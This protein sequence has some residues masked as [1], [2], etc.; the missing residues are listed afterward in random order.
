MLAHRVRP[1]LLALLA[2]AL[3]LPGVASSPPAAAAAGAAASCGCEESGEYDTPSAIEDP[4]VGGDGS[5]APTNPTYRLEA[6]GGAPSVSLTVR[7][8]AGNSQVAVIHTTHTNWGFSP[9]QQRLV[10]WRVSA[11]N[12]ELA[13]YDLGSDR[14]GTPVLTRTVSTG[15]ARLGF[16]PGG[17]WFAMAWMVT[18][19]TNQAGLVLADTTTGD[20]AYS[21]TYS[22]HVAPGGERFGAAGWGF[23]PD[24]DRFLHAHVT[25]PSMVDLALVDLAAGRRTWTTTMTG[26]GHWHFSPCGTKLAVVEQTSASQMTTRLVDTATGTVDA[27]RTSAV[28]GIAFEAAPAGHIA[29]VAGEPIVLAPNPP[30]DCPDEQAPT[31][32]AGAVLNA[33]DVER[34]TLSLGWTAATD[35]RAVTGYRVYRGTTLLATVADTVY[36]VTGL[37]PDTQ[38]TFRVDAVDAAGNVSPGPTRTVRTQVNV[39]TWPNGSWVAAKEVDNDGFVVRWSEAVDVGGVTG[40]DIVVDGQKRAT[41]GP[42]DRAH[43]VSGLAAGTTYAV[44]VQATNTDGRTTTDGPTTTVT[45]T[46]FTELETNEIRGTVYHD[47]NEN[48]GRDAGEPGLD[49]SDPDRD[50]SPNNGWYTVRAVRVEGTRPVDRAEATIS[51]TGDFV[52]SGLADGKWLVSSD[53]HPHRQ[54]APARYQPF[55]VRIVGGVGRG[56]LAFGLANEPMSVPKTGAFA[57]TVYLDE[58]YDHVRDPGEPGVEGV[59]I[60]CAH[61]ESRTLTDCDSIPSSDGSGGYHMGG[62]PAGTVGTG[63]WGLPPRGYY[64]WNVSHYLDL[65]P[66][67]LVTG[68]DLGLVQGTATVSGSVFH[69]RD[70][71][72]VRGESE[73]PLRGGDFHACVSNQALRLSECAPL[74]E[75]GR[76]EIDDVPPGTHQLSVSGPT[77]WWRTTTHGR[78]V[79]VPPLR[80]ASVTVEEELGADGP[81]GTVSGVLFTDTDSDGARDEGEPGRVGDYV[82]LSDGHSELNCTRTAADDPGTTVDEAGRYR[83]RYVPHGTFTMHAEPLWGSL[84]L[85]QT[86][87]QRRIVTSD[88]D[89]TFDVAAR[90]ILPP[91]APTAVE[92]TGRHESLRVTWD[93]PTLDEP[94]HRYEIEVSTD[95][96]DT[97]F[98]NYQAHGEATTAD[99]GGLENGEEYLVRMR[100]ENPAGNSEWTEPVAGTPVQG[101]APAT[102]EL[103]A[104]AGDGEVVLT[105]T[106]PDDGGANLGEYLLEQA[107]GDGEWTPVEDWIEPGMVVGGL[108]NGTTHRFRLAAV[109][110]VGPSA[111]SEA[112]ATPRTTPGEPTG[113]AARVG[114]QGATLTWSAPAD[115]GGAE[116]TS[117][118]VQRAVG[119][120]DWVEVATPRTAR[121]VVS[122]L[123]AG[124]TYRF[125]VAAVNAAGRGGWSEPITVVPPTA[126]TEPSAPRGLRAVAARRTVRLSWQAPRTDGGSPVRDYVVQRAVGRPRGWTVVRDARSTGT[127][128]VVRGLAPGRVHHFRVAAVNAAGRGDWT[129]VT[130]RVRR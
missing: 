115:D 127:R 120:G 2:L 13:L 109:N 21:T 79:V 94:V 101:S 36:S 51:T 77:P 70:E 105:W 39:P 18:N 8:V 14:P 47:A 71:D 56:G 108:V 26:T 5:S 57:G 87:A 50:G 63:V 111:W 4:Y 112:S 68:V 123:T 58:D 7:R 42:D 129:V 34:R 119:S 97:W 93:P 75:E 83:M 29:W 46:S 100:A 32:P 122:R 96:G 125:R 128:L 33:A 91:G 59:G 121:V 52:F 84:R 40:Y 88:L 9:D 130:V 62:V 37:T 103:R 23:S 16:S 3:V 102:P 98:G 110:A 74:D 95:E 31:W 48:G 82:C 12:L 43:T 27:S 64:E 25:S 22:F 85:T 67:E 66:G 17:G 90:D 55:V 10:T 19:T 1:V 72:E 15:D 61:V 54:T 81:S 24:G 92:A 20:I 73:G 53:F 104:T 116:V 38:Y 35:D 99:L 86:P 65:A 45:T 89:L 69:D 114:E 44:A 41:V 117:Y 49:P 28:T 30:P 113:L 106:A 76:Y 60:D 107:T 78:T 126:S 11:P 124:T 6:S 118:V 80:D